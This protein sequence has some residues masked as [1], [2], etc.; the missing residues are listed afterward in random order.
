MQ[1]SRYKCYFLI[2]G[3]SKRVNP[4]NSPFQ[5]FEKKKK[6]TFLYIC[7]LLYAI[8]IFLKKVDKQYS[9]IFKRHHKMKNEKK[10]VIAMKI[11][12]R[13][14]RKRNTY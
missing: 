8:I 4:S 9:E 11:V 5:K 12:Q 2:R 3:T 6:K 13:L 1:T 14:Q 10:D 7:Y